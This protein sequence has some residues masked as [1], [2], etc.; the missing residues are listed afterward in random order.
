MLITTTAILDGKKI[1][2]YKELVFVQTVTGFSWLKGF[3]A[4]WR[5]IAGGRSNTHEEVVEQARQEAMQELVRK[6]QAMGANGIIGFKLDSEMISGGQGGN[7]L[8]MVKVYGTAVV[9]E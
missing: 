4:A 9:I 5:D 6:A 1:V 7:G 3:S 2:E 8:L